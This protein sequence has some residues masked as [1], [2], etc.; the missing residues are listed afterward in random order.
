MKCNC[1]EILEKQI[2]VLD[3]ERQKWQVRLKLIEKHEFEP[4]KILGENDAAMLVAQK[5]AY[6]SDM[7]SEL[8][9]SVKKMKEVRDREM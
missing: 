4:A 7:I 6:L 1:V 9:L 5:I 8:Y 2:S 3:F